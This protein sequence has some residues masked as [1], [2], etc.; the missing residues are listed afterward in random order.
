MRSIFLLLLFTFISACSNQEIKDAAPLQNAPTSIL[1]LAPLNRSM[2]IDA[3]YVYLA[4]LNKPLIEK[5]Y[6]VYPMAVVDQFMRFNG[7]PTPADMHAVPLEKLQKTFNTDAVLYTTIN[8]WG[9]RYQLLSSVTVIH[10]MLRLVDARTGKLLWRKEVNYRQ[11]SQNGGQG[12][13]GAL[14]GAVVTQIM[15]SAIDPMPQA[16]INANAVAFWRTRH[17]L[18]SGP[19]RPTNIK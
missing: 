1:V 16:A 13:A 8:D 2:S 10:A 9:Q 5:G 4:S 12:L 17:P 19:Y 7:L 6:Y 3:S 11:G 15:S 14:V 18:P